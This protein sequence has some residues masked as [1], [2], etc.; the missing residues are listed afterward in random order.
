MANV[1][2]ARDSK[3]FEDVPVIIEARVGSRAISVQE[4]LALKPDS[5]LS[6]EKPAG[7]ALDLIAGNTRLG[8]AEVVVIDNRLALRITDFDPVLCVPHPSPVSGA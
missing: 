1:Q 3:R 4:V 2:T 7:E 6:L 8:S 5:V